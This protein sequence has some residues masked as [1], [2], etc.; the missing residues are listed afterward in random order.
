MVSVELVRAAVHQLHQREVAAAVQPHH[1]HPG[2]GGVPAGGHRVE[3]HRLRTGPAAHHRPHR[4]GQF[5]TCRSRF[6]FFVTFF[7]F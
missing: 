5:S 2:A 4:Q 6:C 1:V 3:V 7:V